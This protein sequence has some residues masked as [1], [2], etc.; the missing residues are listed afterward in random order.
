MSEKSLLVVAPS[1][2]SMKMRPMYHGSRWSTLPTIDQ[3]A[4][5]SR[6]P[7]GTAMVTLAHSPKR[8]V[9]P[10]AGSE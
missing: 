4:T 3:P 9:R 1:R 7:R 6:Q 8:F 2:N 5:L 10:H